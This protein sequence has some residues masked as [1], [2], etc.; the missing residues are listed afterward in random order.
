[1]TESAEAYRTDP[2]IVDDTTWYLAAAR[3]KPEEAG[4]R[5]VGLIRTMATKQ[6]QLLENTDKCIAIFQWGGA[7]REASPTEHFPLE[8]NIVAFNQAK[9][10]C[11]TVVTKVCKPRISPMP[12][13]EGGGYLQRRRAKELG[14][15]IE[16]VLDDNDYDQLVEDMVAD[17]ITTDHAAGAVKVIECEDDIIL[18]HVPIEDVWFD[19]A[20]IRQR[21]PRSCYHVPRTG[22]DVYVALEEYGDTPAKRKAIMHAAHRPA[23]WRAKSTAGSTL[24]VDIYEAWHLPSGRPDECEEEYTDDETGDRKTRKVTRHDGRHTI[25]VDGEDGTLVDEPWSEDHF[26]I[27]MYVPRK[28]RRSIWGM[29]LMRDLIAPQ[30]EYEK[31]TAKVQNQNQKMGVAG[32]HSTVEANL[33]VRE[34]EAGTFGAGFVVE[35]NTAQPP[36]PIIIDAVSPGTYAY[37][38]SIPRAMNERNGVSTLS[39]SSQI[40]QSI[41]GSGKSMQVYQDF[42]DERLLPYHRERERHVIQLS[43]VIVCTAARIVARKGDFHARYR[44]KH[45]FKKIDWKK[46]LEDKD[47]FILRVFPISE[48]SKQPAA[49]F[50]QLTELFDKG[51]ITAEQFKRLYALP[52]LEAENELDSSDTD[53][54][55]RTLDKMVIDGKYMSP[56]PFDNLDLIISRGGKF[57]DLCRLNDVPEDRLK[58]VRD[59]ISDARSMKQQAAT[60]S[61]N[62]NAGPYA[63]PAPPMPP[64][65][66]PGMVPPDGPLPGMPMPPPPGMAPPMAPQMPMAA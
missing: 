29:S 58:L 38:E 19:E 42:E 17:A 61:A 21:K 12:L 4:R 8:E 37:Q 20:E 44:D 13:T 49:K 53:I 43:W 31:L 23:R 56:E 48:L 25:A 64:A 2:E 41:S 52:D 32:W 65:G 16:G 14:Q 40:P 46:A 3:G 18:E 47:S 63:P 28:R 50:A 1:M 51:V 10:T 35:T 55:D 11:E 5:L 26:P 33:N 59:F 6:T 27:V 66:P 34:I 54:I 9:N 45:G 60:A 57:Y 15:A 30:R 39:T 36:T 62:T 22:V 24:R 7:A